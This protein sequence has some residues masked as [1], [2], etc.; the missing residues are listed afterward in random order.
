MLTAE[1]TNNP[2]LLISILTPEMTAISLS[3]QSSQIARVF[4]NTERPLY[5]ATGKI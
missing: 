1:M 2:D 3:G 5:T 4:C